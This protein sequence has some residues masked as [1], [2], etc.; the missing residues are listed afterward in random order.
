MKERGK[1]TSRKIGRNYDAILLV[2]ILV[3]SAFLYYFL[4]AL[5]Q[6][7]NDDIYYMETAY[8][9]ASGGHVLAPYPFAVAYG[10]VFP[11]ALLYKLFGFSMYA[12][13]YYQIFLTLVSTLLVYKI[14]KLYS[15]YAGVIAAAAFAFLPAV[16]GTSNVI[17]PD[18]FTLACALVAAF[19]LL[20]YLSN[21]A[22]AKRGNIMLVLSGFF[23]FA[24]TFGSFLG[25]IFLLFYLISAGYMLF[26][27]G[28]GRKFLF[29]LMG[30]AIGFLVSVPLSYIISSGTYLAF[31]KGGSARYPFLISNWYL[32]RFLAAGSSMPQPPVA[33]SLNS[34][35]SNM[36][37]TFFLV[38]DN[39]VTSY[40]AVIEFEWPYAYGDLFYLLL[41]SFFILF[42][43]KI[44][45]K[46][47]F[48]IA[49]ALF[50]GLPQLLILLLLVYDNSLIHYF[51]T[52]LS[53]IIYFRFELLLVAPLIII[54]GYS[55]SEYLLKTGARR[56]GHMHLP[57][58]ALVMALVFVSIAIDIYFGAMYS[59]KN[60][61]ITNIYYYGVKQ[62]ALEL[63]SAIANGSSGVYLPSII[64]P[65]VN[66][67]QDIMFYSSLYGFQPSNFRVLPASCSALPANSYV[68]FGNSTAAPEPEYYVNAT[69]Y[70][71]NC[72]GISR[73][74]N[75]SNN[76]SNYNYVLYKVS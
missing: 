23:S 24:A 30:I 11:L 38:P 34:L 58:Y 37:A 7:S 18:M 20:S 3:S 27:A 6:P 42:K 56:G 26:S 28:H 48:M 55:L 31:A 22:V 73:I 53:N 76:E 32:F 72:T 51:S 65:G 49:W 60:I 35:F 29:A 14:A 44:I 19:T 66:G 40:P 5:P 54:F 59:Y 16:I 9:L 57:P 46:Q 36:T 50:M 1:R 68:V 41:V 75:T 62:L 45:R 52:F 13:V 25:Y 67:R 2:A 15:K 12:G 61:F 69:K 4:A 21:R 17:S 47:G 8:S 39:T 43:Y 74:Y 33:S 70:F 71:S 63:H 10:I 64:V